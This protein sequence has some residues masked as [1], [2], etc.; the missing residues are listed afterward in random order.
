[1]NAAE[2]YAV[3]PHITID[4][5]ASAEAFA[6]RHRRLAEQI[7]AQRERD[8][9]GRPL[10]P[11]LAVWPE[12]IGT[13]LG[14]LGRVDAVRGCATAEQAMTR[15]GVRS[16]PRVLATMLRHRSFDPQ[17]ALFTALAPAIHRV[18]HDTFAAIAVEHDL[19]VVA[20]SAILPRNRLGDGAA[21]FRAAGTALHNTSYVF[22]P[23]G[24]LAAVVRKVNPVPTQEDVL[25]ICG[26][27]SQE[28]QPIETPFGRLATLICYDGFSEAHTAEEPQFVACGPLVDQLGAQIVAQPSAN[29]WS[30]DAPWAFNEP[31]EDL[32]R[33]DQWFREGMHDQLASL[34]SVRYVVNPQIVGGVLD[35]HF[36]APSL[37]MART[38][39][40]GVQI[41]ARASS[42]SEE[43][44]LRVVV[45]LPIGPAS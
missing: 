36:E 7:A 15:I 43:E 40:G 19:W 20:G 3:Q 22:S 16:A 13:F 17:R 33:R 10:R 41:L 5:Y 38:D 45:P 26:A 8:S 28:L 37:I 23:D 42:I 1:M 14:L 25:G 18:Y 21:Q 32:L 34:H 30:W 12:M 9:S 27:P 35:A 24:R 44:I 29:A 4:D 6:G 11:A 2:L 39:E 31:G